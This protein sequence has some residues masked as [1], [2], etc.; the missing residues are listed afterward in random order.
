MIPLPWLTYVVAWL[1]LYPLI[2]GVVSRV[3]FLYAR[4]FFFFQAEDGIRDYKVTGVQTCALPISP[5]S[6]GSA[7]RR[8]EAG[9]GIRA[10]RRRESS[11][12]RGNQPSRRPSS[13]RGAPRAGPCADSPTPRRRRS[14]AAFRAALFR[15]EPG[16]PPAS[17]A[18]PPSASR[19]RR[20]ASRSRRT[21]RSAGSAA[22]GGRRT[23]STLPRLCRG[24]I[25]AS[26]GKSGRRR[27]R[28]A[29]RLRRTPP[30]L[31][32]CARPRVPRRP[33]RR[34]S[35]SGF[36][37]RQELAPVRQVLSFQRCLQQ[38]AFLGILVSGECAAL[39][40]EAKIQQIGVRAVGLAVVADAPD[41]ALAVLLPYRGPAH[42]ELAREAGEPGHLVERHV[43][44]RLV[45][46]EHVHQVEVPRVVAVD[47][48]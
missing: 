37:E 10:C 41:L 20:A 40:L 17:A 6:P 39:Q 31:P 21:R 4:L 5:S 3:V 22:R 12:A 43:V 15:C 1:V 42:A 46:G 19:H 7:R 34:C 36:P 23:R 26:P 28:P 47:V 33:A 35:G 27:A 25:S 38:I 44:A 45:Q 8:W 18:S 14:A 48:V 9:H 11:A 2:L 32:G 29:T 30:C 16:C 13:R 24:R